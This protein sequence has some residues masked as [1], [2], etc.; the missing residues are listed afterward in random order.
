[1][2][3]IETVT[4]KFD[5]PRIDKLPLWAQ[6]L[7]QEAKKAERNAVYWNTR[8]DAKS[9][10]L[11]QARQEFADNKGAVQYDTWVSVEQD[12]YEAANYGLGVGRNVEF[13]DPAEGC[14]TFT[15]IHKDGGLNIHVEGPWLL[16][17]APGMVNYD[18]R[19]ELQ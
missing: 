11:D 2:T 3:V 16:K 12:D 9:T 10:E 7:F 1:M 5:D 8:H 6:Q 17:P 15:V 19:I 4:T 18:L 14:S 13:G